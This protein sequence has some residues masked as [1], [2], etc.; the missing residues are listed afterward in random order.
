MK[1]GNGRG[2][3]LLHSSCSKDLSSLWLDDELELGDVLIDGIL[4]SVSLES[5]ND[6]VS[7]SVKYSSGWPAGAYVHT[8]STG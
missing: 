1:H 6:G 3:S 5:D 7:T 2:R 8:A 4:L